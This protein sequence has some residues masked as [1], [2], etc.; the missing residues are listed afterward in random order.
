MKKEQYIY[1]IR[2]VLEAI[3]SGK[4]FGK[5]MLQNG[6]KGETFRELFSLIRETEIS[7]QFVPVEKLN[8]LTQQNHQG[9]VALVSEITFYRLEELLPFVYEKGKLPFF[10]ILDKITDVRNFGAI[11]RTA[12]CAGVD[13]LIIPGRGSAPINSDAVK[14]SAGAIYKVPLVRSQNL[15]DSIRFLK[16]SGLTIIGATEKSTGH[17]YS[18]DYNKP[19]AILMG[20]EG[21]GISPEYLKLCDLRVK[22]PLMGE[23][24]SLNVS[25][26]AGII[27]YEVL[28][29]REI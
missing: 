5:I 27:L 9:V 14:T 7:Y 4:E 2:P 19:V 26:A 10:L 16:E 8:R 3:K 17:H 13:G 23:I 20:S 1:G 11:V 25:V 29:Q 15:K 18:A 21:E 24:E 12:E 6:L 28:R 22:I